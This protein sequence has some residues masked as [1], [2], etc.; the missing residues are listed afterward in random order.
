MTL[1]AYWEKKDGEVKFEELRNHIETGNKIIDNIMKMKNFP[2]DSD[3]EKVVK[4]KFPIILE[5]EDLEWLKF[6]WEVHDIGKIFYQRNVKTRKD[7]TLYL[8]FRGHE[9]LSTYIADE[10]FKTWWKENPRER[11]EDFRKYRHLIAGSIMYHH[12]AMGVRKRSVRIISEKVLTGRGNLP[13]D[14]PRNK[15]ELI[16]DI[17]DTFENDVMRKGIIKVI[18][19]IEDFEKFGIKVKRYCEYLNTKIWRK[20][21]GEVEFRRKF[22]CFITIILACDYFSAFKNRGIERKTTFGKVIENFIDI[23]IPL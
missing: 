9:F 7:G 18:N 2:E 17:L 19:E 20:F 3:L 16:E 22:L 6:C 15:E 14:A 13:E 5:K 23:Y 1:Y 11:I 21:A 12:H 10:I 4:M 8:S